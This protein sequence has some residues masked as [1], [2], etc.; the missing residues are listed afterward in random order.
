MTKLVLYHSPYSPFSRSVLL[1]CRYLDIDIE[2]KI[3]DLMKDEQSTPEFLQINPQHCVPT[4]DDNGFYLWESRAILSYLMELRAPQLIPT[5]PKEK[6]I[7]NQRLYFELGDLGKKYA[8]LYVRECFFYHICDT[9]KKNLL[10][11][12]FW[13]WNRN[14]PS[15]DS[16]ALWH[17]F[18][19]WRELFSKWKRMDSWWKYNSSWLCICVNNCWINCK[20]S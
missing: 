10:A 4:I 12:T 1:C 20:F 7:V 13:R 5:S 6:A 18:H 2:V 14:Q 19:H 15:D 11:S 17:F 16:R 9:L 8:D 3:L